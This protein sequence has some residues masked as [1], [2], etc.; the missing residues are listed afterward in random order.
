MSVK[1][2]QIIPAE[3]PVKRELDRLELVDRVPALQ[4][5]AVRDLPNHPAVIAYINECAAL[6]RQ[7]TDLRTARRLFDAA[8]LNYRNRCAFRMQPGIEWCDDG[9]FVSLSAIIEDRAAA[10]HWRKVIDK[11]EAEKKMKEQQEQNRRHVVRHRLRSI[12]LA[13]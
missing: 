1:K 2:P 8:S 10:L 4:R 3:F 5:R 13:S 12:G 11:L 6:A 7:T 9:A